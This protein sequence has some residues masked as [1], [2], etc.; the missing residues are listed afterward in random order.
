MPYK[1]PEEKAPWW[2]KNKNKRLDLDD[3]LIGI[4]ETFHWVFSWRGAMVCCT[5]FTIFAAS[6][7][8]TAWVKVFPVTQLGELTPL[9]GVITWGVLQTFELMPILDDLTLGASLSALIRLQR[10]PLELPVVSLEEPLSAKRMKRYRNRERNQELLGEFIR[11]ACYGLEI[12]V[13][14]VG[15]QILH[16]TGINW[17]A[18]LLALIGI[19]GVEVGIRKTNECGEKLLNQQEREFLQSLRQ[20]TNTSVK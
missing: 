3:L 7:N 8:I 18:V 2:D 13:L 14:I 20:T 5:A 16:S 6:L 9:A 15:G 19:I 1:M 17:G 12:S 4:R 11:Y 10:K